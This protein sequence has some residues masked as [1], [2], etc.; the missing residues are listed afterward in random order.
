[1]AWDEPYPRYGKMEDGADTIHA[2]LAVDSNL[3]EDYT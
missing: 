2:T 3:I 1:M